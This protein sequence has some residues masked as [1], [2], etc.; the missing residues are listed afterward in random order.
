MRV[1]SSRAIGDITYTVTQLGAKQGRLVLARIARIVG[2]AAESATPMAAFTQA[3]SDDD[4]VF[5][6]DTFAAMTTYHTSTEPSKEPA[7]APVFDLHFAGKYAEMLQW[8]WFCVEV[9]FASFFDESNLRALQ[10]MVVSQSTSPKA[11]T[12]PSGVSSVL[13]GGA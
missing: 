13:A 1:S 7:L 8:L 10:A 9:N 11:P 6:C 5:L 4:F 2:A 3:L 12:G